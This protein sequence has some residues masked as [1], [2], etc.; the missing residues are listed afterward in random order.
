[1]HLL[2]AGNWMRQPNERN[3]CK[4]NFQLPFKVTLI[5]VLS[6][7]QVVESDLSDLSITLHYS[8]VFCDAIEIDVRRVKW[9]AANGS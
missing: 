9:P 8:F 1:M 7:S 5:I 3:C 6:T 4:K 2:H